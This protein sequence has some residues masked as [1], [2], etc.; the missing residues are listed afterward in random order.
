M[1]RYFFDV[2]NGTEAQDGQGITLTDR[3]AA[4]QHSIVLL[5]GI[6]C[7]HRPV[8]DD[9]ELSCSVRDDGAQV[10]YVAVLALRGQSYNSEA[11]LVLGRE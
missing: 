11:P 4:R 8:S 7:N 3:G 2:L 9:L 10:I 6:L 5:S 1:P